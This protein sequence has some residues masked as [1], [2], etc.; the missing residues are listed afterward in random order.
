MSGESK[1][2]ATPRWLAWPVICLLCLVWALGA[3]VQVLFGGI[4]KGGS[5]LAEWAIDC[6]DSL[7]GEP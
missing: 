5:A 6:I 2:S 7:G 4:G 1:R 3:L